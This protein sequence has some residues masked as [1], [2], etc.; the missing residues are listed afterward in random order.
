MYLIAFPL[1]LFCK[2]SLFE[3]LSDVSQNSVT[4]SIPYKKILPIAT[5]G[6]FLGVLFYVVIV[7][8][9]DL[10]ALKIEV[11][12][13]LIGGVGAVIN[14]GPLLGAALFGVLKQKL[15]PKNLIAIG[16]A[17]TKEKSLLSED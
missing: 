5:I 9:G 15:F 17:F 6:L 14:V 12:P 3:P 11:S 1:A 2:V 13:A 4:K 7:K 8:L 16:M 10:L